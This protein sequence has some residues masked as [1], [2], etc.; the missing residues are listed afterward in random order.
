MKLLERKRWEKSLGRDVHLEALG[1]CCF[2]YLIGLGGRVLLVPGVFSRSGARVNCC[3]GK[4][5]LG[6]TLFARSLGGLSQRRL[7]GL[8]STLVRWFPPARLETR[9]KESIY[10][11]SLR[12]EKPIGELKESARSAPQGTTPADSDLLGRV[13]ARA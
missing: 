1:L 6:R 8:R 13:C 11:A 2:R 10:Y 5:P 3:C 4:S 7:R 12:V 9:T